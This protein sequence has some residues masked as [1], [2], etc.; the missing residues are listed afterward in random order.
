MYTIYNQSQLDNQPLT[1][2]LTDKLRTTFTSYN[3]EL[4]NYYLVLQCPDDSPMK[5]R[6]KTVI[7]NLPPKKKEKSLNVNTKKG[8]RTNKKQ[9][10]E[11]RLANPNGE[12]DTTNSNSGFINSDFLFNSLLA[13]TFGLAIV[14]IVKQK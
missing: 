6:V 4:E 3:E 5:V 14:Y 2:R 10:F 11:K 12:Q 8:D 13:L 7:T 9:F 1:N